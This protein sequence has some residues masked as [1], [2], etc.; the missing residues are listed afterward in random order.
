[1]LTHRAAAEMVPGNAASALSAIDDSRS[2]LAFRMVA[3]GW[4]D[5][6][7]GLLAGGVIAEAAIRSLML[8]ACRWSPTRPA[9]V[10]L[11]GGTSAVGR[12]DEVLRCLHASR[13]RRPCADPG[14]AG[15]DRLLARPRSRTHG[16]FLAAGV[17]VVPLT[18]VF[19]RWTDKLLRARLQA[20]Q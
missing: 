12:R 13:L 15:R 9:A 19:G 18:V 8:F 1:M 6:A 10:R 16:V 20:G 14:R 5:L 17:L 11:C 3:P 4:Y 2:W 7:L